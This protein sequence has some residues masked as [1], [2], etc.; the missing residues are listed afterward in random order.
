MTISEIAFALK[1]GRQAILRSPRV[2]D[3]PGGG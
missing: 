1:N 3:A 2:E